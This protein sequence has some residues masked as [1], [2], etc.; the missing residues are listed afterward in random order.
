MKFAGL[1][2]CGCG[3]CMA[4][5]CHAITITRQKVHLLVFLRNKFFLERLL[6]EEPPRFVCRI[7]ATGVSGC[8][9]GIVTWCTSPRDVGLMGA[10][11]MFTEQLRAVRLKATLVALKPEELSSVVFVI[12]CS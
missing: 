6:A 3:L 1:L 4:V 5:V 8:G 10:G 12:M 9:S 11:L 7:D 2:R